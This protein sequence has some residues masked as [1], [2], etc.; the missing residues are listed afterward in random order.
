MKQRGKFIVLEG[1]EGSGKSTLATSL[2]KE[3]D[4]VLTHEPGGTAF[5]EELREMVLHRDL[6][7]FT[8]FALMWAARADHLEK[9]ILPALESGRHVICDRFDGSTFAYQVCGEECEALFEPFRAMRRAYLKNAAPDLYLILD[10]SPKEGLARMGR[11]TQNQTVFDR[12]KEEFH[13]SV[14]SGFEEF[15]DL[16]HGKV[17]MLDAS[18]MPEAVEHQAR[19]L[20]KALFSQDRSF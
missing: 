19:E 7:V 20:I 1:G 3:L 4:A 11:A 14:R 16:F 18:K 2:A 17:R 5:S 9:T 10:V 15:Q 13:Q 12:R 8:Q 6:S